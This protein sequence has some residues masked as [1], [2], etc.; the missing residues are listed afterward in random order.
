MTPE[1]VTIRY[2]ACCLELLLP[3]YFQ[4]QTISKIRK[5]LKLVKYRQWQNGAAHETLER[6]F[7]EWEQSLK[8]RHACAEFDLLIAEYKAEEKRRAVAALGTALDENIKRQ[9]DTLN[10]AKK[11]IRE[12]RM[13]P[14]KLVMY[15]AA[16][17][18]AMKPRA[19]HEAAVKKVKS[20]EREV[21]TSKTALEHGYK[22][23][24]AYEATKA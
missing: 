5:T 14:E 21:K 1:I 10:R 2:D 11:A 12:K 24:N 8:D 13:E 6:F 15:K 17:D 16:Y 18:A 4:E 22:V 19:D 23:F 9:R 3:A 7:P 20:L